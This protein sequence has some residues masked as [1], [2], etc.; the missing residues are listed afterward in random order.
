MASPDDRD[1]DRTPPFDVDPDDPDA[2][3]PRDSPLEDDDR[4]IGAKIATD[5]EAFL[6]VLPHFYR[7][8][9]SQANGAQ[10]RI[11]RTT[12]WAIALIAALLSLVFSSRRMPAF[13]LLVGLFVLS[14]FLFYEV[15]RYRFYDHWRAR[16]RFVQ[17]N[18][19]ANAL[20][21]VGTEHPEWREELSA[22]LR[23]PTFKVSF[24]EGLSRRIRRVY[25]LLFT[26]LG[27]AWVFKVTLFTPE[28]RWTEA[29]ELPGLP[30]IWVAV[31]LAVFHGCIF[32]LAFWPTERRAKGEIHGSEPGDWKND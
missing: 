28:Q 25:G 1:D 19:F 12:D 5:Q 14:I 26:V 6:G 29:A 16:V 20:D 3:A 2:T 18:V 27:V 9:V 32:A 10:D 31:A 4:E 22:D 11:D 30:G 7:G 13:L 21:P 15:R 24:L 23:H 8:E 17:E